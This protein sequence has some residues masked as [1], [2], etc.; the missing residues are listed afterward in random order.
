MMVS[1]LVA[2]VS[3]F[4]GLN[5][6]AGDVPKTVSNEQA[7]AE[8]VENRQLAN[9]LW[10]RNT[11][12]C[13][14]V[15]KVELFKVMRETSAQLDA[16]PTDHLKYRARF[17]YS[18]CQQMLLDVSFINGSCINGP[19]STHDIEHVDQRWGADSAQC[20]AEI[21]APDLTLAQTEE[22]ITEAKWEA[23]RRKEGSTDEEIAVMKAIRN[24]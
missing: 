7:A 22:E 1:R 15:D 21:A 23:E 14:A 6:Y 9:E 5:A 24:L 13:M 17:V 4:V 19:P 10:E 12:A 8:A 11:K 20:N 18:G 2:L 3:L 16:Q